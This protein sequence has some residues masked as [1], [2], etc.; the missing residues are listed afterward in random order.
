MLFGFVLNLQVFKVGTSGALLNW[1][2]FWLPLNF[3][4]KVIKKVCGTIAVYF[5]ML[6]MMLSFEFP[7]YVFIAL[8]MDGNEVKCRITDM[9][10]LEYFRDQ[11]QRFTSQGSNRRTFW[12]SKLEYFP[13]LYQSG[14][15]NGLFQTKWD[16]IICMIFHNF[17]FT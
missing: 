16:Q 11:Y 7:Q 8:S 3:F 15:K 10:T 12:V 1:S 14:E 5:K 4:L 17:F 6:I 9:S 13:M 2:D